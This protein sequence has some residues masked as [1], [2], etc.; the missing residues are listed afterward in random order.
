MASEHEEV[1]R[2]LQAYWD[3]QEWDKVA[4][5]LIKLTGRVPE[6]LRLQMQ[7]AHLYLKAGNTER[8]L[9]RFQHCAQTSY[10]HNKYGEALAVATLI[11]QVQPDSRF[12]LEMVRKSRPRLDLVRKLAAHPLKEILL[13]SPSTEAL[14]ELA[15]CLKVLV[16]QKGTT[17]L[18][19]GAAG[20]HFFLI[21]RGEVQVYVT[22]RDG[23]MFPLALI[24][25]GDFFG[26][27]SLVTGRRR[28]ATVVA[29]QRSELWAMVRP[30]FRR[31]INKYPR[32]REV[33]YRYSRERIKDTLARIR[34]HGIERRRFP[35]V[36]VGLEAEVIL[37]EEDKPLEIGELAGLLRDL[38]QIGACFR[39]P[40]SDPEQWTQLRPGRKGSVS[41]A[42]EPSVSMCLNCSVERAQLK[43]EEEQTYM[44]LGLSFSDI[45]QADK[46]QIHTFIVG[47]LVFPRG[48][49]R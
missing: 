25:E 42:L 16:Y 14:E 40:V 4:A 36:L 8:A 21:H 29:T 48:S 41:F 27:I 12:A 22:D 9:E 34:T 39:V 10:E 44:E 23:H 6:N 35:R 46:E 3:R 47:Q 1:V 49:A 33:V 11:L 26:E 37:L 45:A 32:F 18:E 30:D 38:S 24:G 19:E 31:F 13:D 5:E 15:S 28:T 43:K 17:I 20:F 2:A 7:L